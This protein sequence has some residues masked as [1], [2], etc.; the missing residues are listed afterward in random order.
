MALTIWFL[1]GFPFTISWVACNTLLL[2]TTEDHMRA[3]TVGTLGSLYGLNSLIAAAT[4]G[5][6]AELYGVLPVLIAAGII[7]TLAGPTYRI[8]SR[9]Q[10]TNPGF[11]L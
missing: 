3:R 11:G 10:N 9:H 4:A 6:T 1:S 2:L 7:Q 5:I 8:M